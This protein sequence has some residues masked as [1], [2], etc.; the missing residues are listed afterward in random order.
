MLRDRVIEL[1]KAAHAKLN[2]QTSSPNKRTSI[3]PNEEPRR[4]YRLDIVTSTF[5]TYKF[6]LVV[7]Q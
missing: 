6:V 3:I 7:Q 1:K 4:N 2:H 5:I